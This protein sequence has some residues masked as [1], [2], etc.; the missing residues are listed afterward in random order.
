MKVGAHLHGVAD[1]R[2]DEPLERLRRPPL[3]EQRQPEDD[4]HCEGGDA[5][6]RHDDQ[7]GD[8]EEQA[9]EHGDAR[10]LEVVGDD[11]PDRKRSHWLVGHGHIIPEAALQ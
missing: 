8:R 1:V 6:E 4:G 2:D 7:V 9:E 5:P 10:P 3:E 11:E